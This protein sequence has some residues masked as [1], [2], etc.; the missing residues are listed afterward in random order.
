MGDLSTFPYAKRRSRVN[1]NR[2]KRP[3]LPKSR[4]RR[5]Q[6][7]INPEIVHIQLA[8]LTIRKHR[9]LACIANTM[10][11]VRT[12]LHKFAQSTAFNQWRDFCGAS[13]TISS[14]HLHA[15]NIP[16]PSNILST[17]LASAYRRSGVEA[18]LMTSIAHLYHGLGGKPSILVAQF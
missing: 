15:K 1:P 6:N 8:P 9:L 2:I 14:L 17:K 12:V 16:T 18:E 3:R 7:H 11:V 4:N 10:N 5:S 13:A